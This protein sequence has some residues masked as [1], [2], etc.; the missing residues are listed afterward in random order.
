MK[1]ARLVVE[2]V[3]ESS[4]SALSSYKNTFFETPLQIGR[5]V[6][7]PI[8][9]PT[10]RHFQIMTDVSIEKAYRNAFAAVDSSPTKMFKSFIL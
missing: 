1:N 2:E 7:T 5:W 6:K 10:S 8:P 4:F 9:P 3:P